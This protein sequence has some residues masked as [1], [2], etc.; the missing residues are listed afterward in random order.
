MIKAIR[1]DIT[2]FQDVEYIACVSNAIGL[3]NSNVGKSIRVQGGREIE[4][5]AMLICSKVKYKAGD[6]YVTN[7]GNLNYKK[8][9]HLVSTNYPN[10]KTNY[11]IIEN[12]LKNLV[13]YCK[14][15]G[16]KKIAI[17]SMGIGVGGLDIEKVSRIYKGV[18]SESEIDFFIV[19][20]DPVF[21][22]QFVEYM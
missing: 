3:L 1:G 2:K 12:C 22:Y 19:D 18:L 9:L 17:P 4:D 7:S 5:E 11:E 20:I 21:I 10:E 14:M 6:I 8:I 15:M 16:V 13:P